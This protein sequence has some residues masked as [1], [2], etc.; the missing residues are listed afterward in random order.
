MRLD[1][2]ELDN[3]HWLHYSNN[4]LYIQEDKSILVFVREILIFKKIDE[5]ILDKLIVGKMIKAFGDYLY[6]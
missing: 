3:L 1:V 5:I 4:F 6:F 2:T